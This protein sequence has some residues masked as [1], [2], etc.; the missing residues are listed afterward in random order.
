MTGRADLAAQYR[1][2]YERALLADEAFRKATAEDMAA[3]EALDAVER[4]W[5][6]QHDRDTAAIRLSVKEEHPDIDP[7]RTIGGSVS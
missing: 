2:A 3:R 4:E 6:L 7:R 5:R 1:M